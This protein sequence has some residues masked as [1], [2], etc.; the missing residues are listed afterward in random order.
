MV[1]KDEIFE[2]N[3]LK[4]YKAKKEFGL[5]KFKQT[6]SKLIFELKPIDV[7]MVKYS[8]NDYTLVIVISIILP[9]IIVLLIISLFIKKRYS[10]KKNKTDDF[11]NKTSKIMDDIE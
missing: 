8:S 3:I 11:I 9:I 1:T 4:N 7:I 6:G 10:E 2:I 5:G